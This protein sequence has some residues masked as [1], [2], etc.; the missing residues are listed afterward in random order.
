ML[1]WHLGK[2]KDD[3]ET[4]GGGSNSYNRYWQYKK[5]F[6][7]ADLYKGWYF[8]EGGNRRLS[9]KAEPTTKENLQMDQSWWWRFHNQIMGMYLAPRW[10]VVIKVSKMNY[11]NTSRIQWIIFY[12]VMGCQNY[13]NKPTL[14][15][16]LTRSNPTLT[17]NYRPISLLNSDHIHIYVD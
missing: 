3:F 14:L 8:F 17:K 12:K 15:Y 5:I 11:H 10:G 2:R 9:P 4:L 6:I 13:G 1:I 7:I 16:Y